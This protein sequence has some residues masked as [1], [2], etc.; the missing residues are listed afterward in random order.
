MRIAILGNYPQDKDRIAGGTSAVTWR[1]A[2]ALSQIPGL[3]VHAVNFVIGLKSVRNETFRKVHEH[4]VPCNPR[5]AETTLYLRFRLS[6][7]PVLREIDP[8][9]IDIQGV[10]TYPR[11]VW[12]TGIPWVV[13]PHGIQSHEVKFKKG[14]RAKLEVRRE[15]WVFRAAKDLILCNDYIL[16]FVK[17]Y[18]KARLYKVANALDDGYFNI[19]NQEEPG[20]I[21]FVGWITPRKGVMHLFRAMNEL[22]K[23]KVKCRLSFVG[24][25]KEP[26]YADALHEYMRENALDDYIKWFGAVDEGHLRELYGKCALLVL[27]SLEESLPTVLAQAMAAGKPCVGANSAGIPFVIRDGKTGFLSEY[28]NAVDLADKIQRL[29]EDKELRISMGK[30]GREVAVAEYSATEVAKTHLAIYHKVI[31]AWRSNG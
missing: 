5:F 17:P 11:F 25:T 10:S 3:D 4:Y 12:N 16:P 18:T 26:D 29:L 20:S 1:L 23:R 31:E 6:I 9:I 8:D 7:G 21:L 2:D 30:A 15:R 28:D 13:T 22:K 27:P 19:P 14:W 24:R